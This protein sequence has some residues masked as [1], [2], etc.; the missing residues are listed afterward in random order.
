M[1]VALYYG[2][3]TIKIE[4]RPIPEPGPGEIVIKN[5]IAF[6]CGTDVKTFFRGY[7]LWDPPYPFGHEAAGDIYAVGEGVEGFAIGDRVIAHNS[8]PCNRCYY[9]KKGQHSMC[10]NLLFNLGAFSEYQLIPKEIVE[11]NTFKIP[12]GID[13]KDAALTEPF[14][15]AVHGI[16]EAGISLGDTVIIN[17]AG[18]LGL[19]MTRLAYLKG[20][21]VITV[22]LSQK[23]LEMAK[24]L[25]ASIVMNVR[26]IEDQVAA[27][28]QFTED[29]RGADVAIEAVGSPE[30]WEKTVRMVRKGGTSILFGGPK[31]GTTIT[32]DT[33]FMHYSQITI[34]G[35][36]HT[37]PRFVQA[38]F[39]LICQGVIHGNDFVGSEYPLEKLE[40]AIRS[41]K[42]GRVIKNAIVFED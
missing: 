29:N 5:K 10:E 34:K 23:R 14:A 30:L 33:N 12:D 7:P 22:D 28:R 9:C 31:A 1:K 3:E 11:Q 27:V 17:G 18:P 40:E 13:Y 6:T 24:K 15:C 4:D 2:P 37:T 20:A 19:M 42:E 39:N 26:D 21:R 25:G 41:H 8:A 35:I 16:E 38:A 36:F 32:L